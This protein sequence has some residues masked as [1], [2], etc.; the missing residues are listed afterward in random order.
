M[1]ILLSHAGSFPPAK[2]SIELEQT[3]TQYL[4]FLKNFRWK[5]VICFFHQLF[6]WCSEMKDRVSS[7]LYK[8]KI[9]VLKLQSLKYKVMKL[10]L[11]SLANHLFP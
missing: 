3:I 5:Y 9:K 2:D 4:H 8:T 1:G 10:A 11:I 6:Q 7:A